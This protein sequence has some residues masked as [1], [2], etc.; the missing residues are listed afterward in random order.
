MYC[1]GVRAAHVCRDCEDTLN[2]RSTYR[3][4]PYRLATFTMSNDYAETAL[5]F[6]LVCNIETRRHVEHI[7]YT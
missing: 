1:A 3:H 2:S 5:A 4:G 7:R 6:L